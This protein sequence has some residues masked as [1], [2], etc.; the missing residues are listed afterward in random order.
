M[1]G[2]VAILSDRAPVERDVV[3][4]AT[5]MLHHRGPDGQRTWV[6]PSGRV[7]L[8]HARLSIIDI[9]AGAQPIANE[10]E[11]VHIV[12]N[13]E[14]YD[15]ER[16]QRE[17]ESRGHKLRTRSDSEILVHLYEEVG[18]KALLQLRGEFAFALWDASNGVLIAGRDRFGIKPLF[19]ARVGGTLYV[20]SEIKALFAAGVPAVWDHESFF[21]NSQIALDSDRT[22]YE[23]VYQVPPGHYLL[24][25]GPSL[26]LVPY[27]D[28]DYPLE[29]STASTCTDR[30]HVERLRSALDEAVRLRLRA[31]VPVGCFLSGGLDSSTVI[32]LAAQQLGR[33]LDAFTVSFDS[34][35]YDEVGIAKETAA[36]LGAKLHVFEASQDMLAENFA[37]AVWHAETT[38][39]NL[40]MVAK[41]LLTRLAR[42][43]GF[44]VMLTGE[45]ADE[46]FLGYA[47]FR[48]DLLLA[49]L[50]GPEAPRVRAMLSGLAEEGRGVAQSLYSLS[51]DSLLPLEGT[52]RMLGFVPNW[53]DGRA[54]TGLLNRPLFSQGFAERFAG[55]DP[56][57]MFLE[58][59]DLNGQVFGRD[60]VHQAAYLFSK[61]LFPSAILGTVADRME[62]A[63]SIEGRMPFMDHHVV[64]L[65][66]D[67]PHGLKLRLDLDKG[68]LVEKFVL[69]EVARPLV[70]DTVYRRKKH[71]FMAPPLR[72]GTTVFRL[73]HDMFRSS[74][75]R[76]M[77]FYDPKAVIDSLDA[78]PKLPAPQQGALSF[79][80]LSILSACVLQERFKVASG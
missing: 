52:R 71:P 46:V 68:T 20:A 50:E 78:Y 54:R 76:D 66:K 59:L 74:A 15:Y 48:M 6:S 24:A 77:P 2:F 23:G 72:E 61:G 60:R 29:S 53:I 14:F 37:D 36:G 7:G 28:I 3:E 56:G 9:E 40:Q 73:M 47:G 38:H 51:S 44:K 49:M 64:E 31:D 21:Q 11:S 39:A 58:R 25:T 75:L 57:R 17:L 55:R 34:D 65:V 12:V 41:F 10:T 45:G 30:E 32:A 27:W 5:R 69:R 35:S 42:D 70:T 18:T 63:H 80:L 4:R 43:S 8:G 26:K 22:L 1:C 13:G 67:M 16:I 79:S 62:M 33:P 19:Y